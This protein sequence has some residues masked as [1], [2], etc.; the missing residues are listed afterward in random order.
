MHVILSLLHSH[1]QTHEGLIARV[2]NIQILRGC[3][4]SSV[5][6]YANFG[7]SLREP[8]NVALMLC[9]ICV[10]N[11]VNIVVYN[12]SFRFEYVCV[13]CILTCW[14]CL[15][16]FNPFGIFLECGRQGV[17]QFARWI[18]EMNKIS[19]SKQKYY[20]Y[21]EKNMLGICTN[22]CDG[23]VRLNASVGKF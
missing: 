19:T 21:G 4:C 18:S 3:N 2:I 11:S 12:T 22:A 8:C 17:R 13:L 5:A 10:A 7:G 1:T 23:F 15:T 6:R 9:G 20:M 16:L 14:I